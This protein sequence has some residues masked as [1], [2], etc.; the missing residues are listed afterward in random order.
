MTYED[1]A[2][3][4]PEDR[5]E[6]FGQEDHVRIYG[7]DYVDRLLAAGFEVTRQSFA[8]DLGHEKTANHA[9][10]ETDDVVLCRK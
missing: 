5:L 1:S 9:L 6:A 3:T 4:E 10:D 7:R 2:I 8:K